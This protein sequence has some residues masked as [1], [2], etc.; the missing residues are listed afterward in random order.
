MPAQ[1]VKRQYRSH[2]TKESCHQVPLPA[3]VS[4]PF[5]SVHASSSVGA[6][7][8][9]IL[10]PPQGESSLR[11]G[12]SL[13]SSTLSPLPTLSLFLSRSFFVVDDASKLRKRITRYHGH[14]SFAH[15]LSLSRVILLRG[16]NFIA[17]AFISRAFTRTVARASLIVRFSSAED[18][19]REAT[20]PRHCWPSERERETAEN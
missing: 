12:A 10:R 19:G 17:R 20:K 8:W 14:A 6:R 3:T 1:A 2:T 13:R 9:D 5:V 15:S 18:E 16:L 11:R 7:L 4:R